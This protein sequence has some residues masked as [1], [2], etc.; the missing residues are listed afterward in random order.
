MHAA[1]EIPVKIVSE[2]NWRGHWAERHRRMKRQKELAHGYCA[3][4]LGRLAVRPTRCRIVLTRIKGYRQRDYDG[5][6]LQS[7]FKAVRDGIALYLGIDDGDDALTWEYRQEKG[8]AAGVRVEI[9]A[10]GIEKPLAELET[11]KG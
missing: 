2:M 10:D 5:D 4:F 7:A 8:R 1:F 6:N 11:L 3:A 9:A